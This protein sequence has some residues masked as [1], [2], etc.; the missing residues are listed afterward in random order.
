M[1]SSVAEWTPVVVV[2]ATTLFALF[3]AGGFVQTLIGGIRSMEAA[4]DRMFGE[5]KQDREKHA[6]IHERLERILELHESQLTELDR[7][8]VLVEER[9][10]VGRS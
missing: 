6:E 4:M 3:K 9:L 8:R 5:L 10:K 1:L 2:L 7:F